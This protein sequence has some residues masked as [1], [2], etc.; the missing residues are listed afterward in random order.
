M[1]D[2]IDLTFP[3]Q[4]FRLDGRIYAVQLLFREVEKAETHWLM[5]PEGVAVDLDKH[6]AVSGLASVMLSATHVRILSSLY[7]GRLEGRASLTSG[8]VTEQQVVEEVWPNQPHRTALNLRPHISRLRKL[9]G[10]GAISTSTTKGVG[11][12]LELLGGNW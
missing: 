5:L 8:H 11:Y 9:L 6:V 3:P 1:P 10:K 7:R 12:R 4:N 2:P